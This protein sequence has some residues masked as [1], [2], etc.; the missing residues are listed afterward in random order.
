MPI[1]KPIFDLVQKV[2]I[3]IRV[4]TQYQVDR[5]S[6]PVQREELIAYCKYVLGIDNFEVFEDPGYSAKNTDRPDYQRMINRVRTGEFSHILV[7]KIDRISR[8]LLDFAAMYAELKKLGVTFVSKNEQ[9]DTSSAMGEAMLKIILVFAELE[10]NMTSER[11]SAIMLSRANGGVWNGGK[12]PFGYSYDKEQKVFHV[13]DDEAK[14]V[15]YIY[16]LYES[17]QS[18]TTVAKQLNEKGIRS[19]TGKPWNPVTVRTMLTNPFYAGT[20]RYNYR[21]E[22]SRT[23]AVKPKDEW[24]MVEDHHPAIVTRERQNHIAGILEKRRRS[25][26]DSRTYQRK[27][28]HIFG[29]LLR[30]G[31]C[32]SMMS[33]TS[34]RARS[35]GWR[36]S[37]YLCTR[38]RRFNDCT[39]K[40]ITDMTIGPFVFNFIANMIRASK[41][42]GKST[43]IETLEKKLL[44]GEALAAVDHIGR[45]G[46]EELY[47]HLRSGFSEMPFDAP[48]AAAAE[49]AANI[50]EREL[51]LSEKR[52]L[53]RALNRLRTLY[54]YSDDSIPEKDYIVERKQLMDSLDEV[55]AKLE[56]A[57]KVAADAIS[58]SD[59][60]FMAKASYFILSQQLQDKRFID[61]ERFIRKIDPKIVKDFLN[62]IATNFCIKDGLTT[63]ILFRNGLEL[64]FFYKPAETA[65]SPETF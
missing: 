58:L 13:L 53:E 40:Y 52:R 28:T 57:E 20:Y 9:F 18:L 51:L 45:P 62:S 16:D 12:I 6:L 49:S 47:N 11:V 21:D 5:A 24:V 14:I 36:P 35:D 1:S 46:L 43:S 55:D 44:R 42:F 31:Y 22:S 34:D 56:A 48:S 30:C 61:Y 23:Y 2:A 15:L 25:N 38:R 65:K 8:N 33:A 59:E 60:E 3:Y 29:G 4:S 63:S 32:G 7:W 27:N 54:L 50:Q 41:S 64:Q 17:I 39:N 10:R 26:F 19:R 37:Q